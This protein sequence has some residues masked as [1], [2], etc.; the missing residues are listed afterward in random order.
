MIN[1]ATQRF[2]AVRMGAQVRTERVDHAPLVTA[3]EPVVEIILKAMA[4]PAAST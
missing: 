3:P 4:A 2:L 1:P